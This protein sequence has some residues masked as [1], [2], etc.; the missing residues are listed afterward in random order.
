MRGKKKGK[1]FLLLVTGFSAKLVFDL[2]KHSTL[3]PLGPL[4]LWGIAIISICVS[5]LL[6]NALS[7]QYIGGEKVYVTLLC[8]LGWSRSLLKSDLDLFYLGENGKKTRKYFG[9]CQLIIP[10]MH[11]WKK[12]ICYIGMPIGVA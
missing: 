8:P 1:F 11:W 4:C 12:V 6:V 9:G 5:T 3:L 2:D 7:H 10:S